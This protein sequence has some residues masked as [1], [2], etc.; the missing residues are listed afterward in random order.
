MAALLDYAIGQ[1]NFELVRDRIATI[2][3]EELDNQAILNG[4]IAVPDPD[5]VADVYIER[6][7]TPSE[8]EGTVI[9]V[10]LDN[11]R[12]DNQTAVSQLCEA[13]Y[14]IDI[15]CNAVED[16]NT[17]GYEKSGK[18]A[19]RI[20][21][22]I[23]AIL[24]SPVYDR[25]RFANGIVE[26]RSVQSMRFAR[27]NDEQDAQYTRMT[28]IDVIVQ[29]NETVTGIVPVTAAGYDTQIKIEL[30]NKGYLLTYNNE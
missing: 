11:N 18:K 16:E 10:N 9:A 26:R 2:V 30:T 23:R 7:S 14:N 25:L 5:L 13:H 21:G 22:V 12:F 24:Q 1:S 17:E 20:A 4:S 6:F 29:V 27:I 3:K 15:F 8:G 28:R 19:A